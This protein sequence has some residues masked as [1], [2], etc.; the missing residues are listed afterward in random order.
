[1]TQT[2]GHQSRHKRGYNTT[3]PGNTCSP[4]VLGIWAVASTKSSAPRPNSHRTPQHLQ[5]LPTWRQDPTVMGPS[6]E[7]PPPPSLPPLHPPLIHPTYNYNNNS[8][9]S[10]P[11]CGPGSNCA[12]RPVSST[13]S[14]SSS[15]CTWTRTRCKA[16]PWG[17]TT[18]GA[19]RP[20]QA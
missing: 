8:L 1:M 6:D 15:A 5:R 4:R 12:T 20:A 19:W 16:R 13:S 18:S 2:T 9:P 10:N 11:T 17:T 3:I 7:I 14:P